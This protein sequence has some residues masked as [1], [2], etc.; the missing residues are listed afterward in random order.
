MIQTR[1]R[2]QACWGASRQILRRGIQGLVCPLPGQQPCATLVV[3]LLSFLK[4][5]IDGGGGSDDIWLPVGRETL[6]GFF[7]PLGTGCHVP[8]PG[9]MG[10]PRSSPPWD[11]HSGLCREQTFLLASVSPVLLRAS[12]FSISQFHPFLESESL[13]EDPSILQATYRISQTAGWHR[14]PPHRDYGGEGATHS[15][16]ILK[17]LEGPGGTMAVGPRK[18]GMRLNSPE[19]HPDSLCAGMFPSLSPSSFS[20]PRP[21]LSLLFL[22]LSL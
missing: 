19:R 12:P 4:K 18:A 20:L 11:R 16:G 3:T 14:D 6:M 7:T 5:L 17:G 1:G 10:P 2:G 15:V 8:G 9:Q 21:S 22:S 13:P